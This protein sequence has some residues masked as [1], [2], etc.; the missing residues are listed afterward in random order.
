MQNSSFRDG[1]IAITLDK[2]R[3]LLFSLNALD[4]LQEQFGDIDKL[5][6]IMQNKDKFKNVRSLL[7]ILLNEGG[8][9]TGEAALTEKEVGRLIHTGN[10]AEVQT[11]IMKAFAK[12]SGGGEAGGNDGDGTDEKNLHSGQE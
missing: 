10:F 11:A 9:D 7:T 3:H 6:E 4:A 12:G 8:A 5:P 1:K 2:E